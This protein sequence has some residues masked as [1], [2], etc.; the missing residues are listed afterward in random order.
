MSKMPAFQ[1]YPADW[2]KDLAVQSLSYHDRG[3]WHEILCLMHESSERGVLLLNG[4]PM[5]I[6]ALANM[7]GLDN[8][9]LTTTLTTLLTFGVARKR[10]DGAIFSKRMVEDDKLCK[11]RRDAGKKG[12]N[13][14]LVNQKSTTPVNQI[15]TPSSSSSTSVYPL[16]PKERESFSETTT[17]TPDELT[18]MVALRWPRIPRQ[19]ADLRQVGA[20][21]ENIRKV[22]AYCQTFNHFP[23]ADKFVKNFAAYLADAN[24]PPPPKKETPI[25]RENRLIAEN[26]KRKQQEKQKNVHDRTSP[27]GIADAPKLRLAD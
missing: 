23:S 1:F 9:I 26:T 11:I 18:C 6:N 25:E 13:P 4:Q 10:E 2:R 14:V 7:L 12:G 20:T 21:P 16:T 19:L 17:E 27:N 8:Q 22:E 3:V 5:P 24:K 15:P